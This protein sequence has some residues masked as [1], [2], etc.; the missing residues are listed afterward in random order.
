VDIIP[1]FIDKIGWVK[2]SHNGIEVFWDSDKLVLT[3]PVQ[4]KVYI[5]GI[6]HAVDSGKHEFKR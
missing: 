3:T 5:G 4:A 6:C 2:A 1:R